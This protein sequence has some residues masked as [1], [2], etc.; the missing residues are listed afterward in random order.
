[1]KF[2]IDCC[3]L[4]INDAEYHYLADYQLIM[5]NLKKSVNILTTINNLLGN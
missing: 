5:C 4:T 1:M 2:L 3:E